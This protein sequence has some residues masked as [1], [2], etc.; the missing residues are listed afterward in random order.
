LIS[1]KKKEEEALAGQGG[2]REGGEAEEDNF[3]I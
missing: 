2:L 1:L 3:F